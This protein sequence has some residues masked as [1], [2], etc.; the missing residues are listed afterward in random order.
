M[1]G[2]GWVPTVGFS[3]DIFFASPSKLI[4]F[5]NI[6]GTNMYGQPSFKIV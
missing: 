1:E 3:L 5:T 2:C 4:S 6:I